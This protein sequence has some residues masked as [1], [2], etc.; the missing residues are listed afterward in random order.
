MLAPE[1]HESVRRKLQVGPDG[2]VSTSAGEPRSVW[3]LA[4]H[5][6]GGGDVNMFENLPAEMTLAASKPLPERLLLFFSLRTAE[7]RMRSARGDAKICAYLG[8]FAAWLA[9]MLI[10]DLMSKPFIP[11]A[12]VSIGL[13]VAPAVWAY[14]RSLAKVG[15]MWEYSEWIDFTSRTWHS[16]RHFNDGSFPDVIRRIPL[17]SLGLF[18]YPRYGDGANYGAGIGQIKEVEAAGMNYHAFVLSI[19]ESHSQIDILRFCDKLAALW[20]IDCFKLEPPWNKVT[21]ANFRALPAAPL[22]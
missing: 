16:R 20:G 14:R 12:L 17:D 15:Q 1:T 5:M 2:V 4:R 19:H 3:E 6:H 21:P 22:P 7:D 11:A 8:L 9:C 18:W 13:V 10:V